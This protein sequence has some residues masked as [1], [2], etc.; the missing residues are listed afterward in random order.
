MK[1]PDKEKSSVTK[2]YVVS[3]PVVN[4]RSLNY[5]VWAAIPSLTEPVRCKDAGSIVFIAKLQTI[6]TAMYLN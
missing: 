2:T 6:E 3:V 1:W 5:M 4:K